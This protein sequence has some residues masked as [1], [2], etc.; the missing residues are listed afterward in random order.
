MTHGNTLV[1]EHVAGIPGDVFIDRWLHSKELKPI[2]IVKELVKF[3]ERSFVRLLGDMRSYNFVVVITPDFEDS[4]IRIRAMDFDQQSHHGRKS[5]YLP[6]Y[7]KDNQ[8]FALFCTQHLHVKTARQ[9]QREEQALILQRAELAAARLT[10]LLDVM[11]HDPIAPHENV[12]S[13]REGL[14]DHF[15]STDYLRCE[16]MGALVRQNLE[17]LRHQI[18]QEDH[19]LTTIPRMY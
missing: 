16:S 14:A 13:L 15:Q 4:Q 17:S 18:S 7:F 2:R 6:Q 1:E 10:R 3:N 12:V 19:P 8:P 5:F 9:Y 11:V